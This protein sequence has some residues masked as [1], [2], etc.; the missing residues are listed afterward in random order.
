[1]PEIIARK[2]EW[3]PDYAVGIERIDQDHRWL[4]SAVDR[5]YQAMLA[6]QGKKQ[7][8]WLLSGLIEYSQRHFS[9]EEQLMRQ[10]HYPGAAAHVRQHEEFRRHI[11]DLYANFQ[12]GNATIT[13]E[14]LQFLTGWLARHTC[15]C[16]RAMAEHL[17]TSSR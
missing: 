16:D 6:G 11:G 8:E 3:Q 10:T 1:M 12:R 7:L 4:F 2:F 9:F 5:L 13:I 17:K 15:D 14:A